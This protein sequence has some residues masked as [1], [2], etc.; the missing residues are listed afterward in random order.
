MRTRSPSIV[1]ETSLMENRRLSHC[2]RLFGVCEFHSC[3]TLPSPVATHPES[4]NARNAGYD[5]QIALARQRTSVTL[6][7]I[8]RAVPGLL[9]SLDRSTETC[10]YILLFRAR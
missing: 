1:N 8:L 7:T 3:F 10:F 6:G 2:D 5:G 4:I 9:M